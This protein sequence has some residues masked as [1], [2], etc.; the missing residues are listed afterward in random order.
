MRRD[1][2]KSEPVSILVPSALVAR[3]SGEIRSSCVVV[4][5]DALVDEMRSASGSVDAPGGSALNV[6]VG[7][8]VLGVPSVLIAMFG[9]DPDGQVL[10]RHLNAY[11]VPA[12]RSPAL[13]GTGR[14]I[15]DRTDGEPRYSFSRAQIERR[16]DFSLA[17]EILSKAEIVAVSGFPF[18]DATQ[19]SQLRAAV[20]G[21]RLYIDPN[22]RPGLLVDRQ[23]FADNLELLAPQTS[24]FKIGADDA[25]I[26]WGDSLKTVSQRLR[27]AG[28]QAVLATEGEHGATLYSADGET[29]HPIAISDRPIV[30]TMGAGD[31][32]FAA[33]I[34]QSLQPSSWDQVLS[35]AMAV[36]AETIRHPGGLLQ[37]PT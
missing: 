9:D 10:S 27:D 24:L 30:D 8:A 7:L 26:I 18:D 25:H 13:L 11:D 2:D 14:A 28:A 4:I 35:M 6:A 1:D 12:V 20:A 34:A 31:S 22:P 16:I 29:H 3:S 23:L 33:V 15:S 36:A 21:S 19:V 17:T 32:T 37:L 5:G